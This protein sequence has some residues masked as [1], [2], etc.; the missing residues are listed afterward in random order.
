MNKPR[1]SEPHY[2]GEPCHR[3]RGT[4]RYTTTRSCVA[5][6]K[7]AVRRRRG[8]LELPTEIFPD[9]PPADSLIAAAWDATPPVVS[10]ETVSEIWNEIHSRGIIAEIQETNARLDTGDDLL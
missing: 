5:C 8:K 6:A 9:Q 7:N 10:R 1:L 3:C 4:Q 2:K